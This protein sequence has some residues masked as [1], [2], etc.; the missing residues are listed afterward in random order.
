MAA[1]PAVAAIVRDNESFS[2]EET[3]RKLCKTFGGGNRNSLHSTRPPS[4][5]QV[6]FTSSK[7]IEKRKKFP[8]TSCCDEN[9]VLSLVM[10]LTLRPRPL[11]RHKSCPTMPGELVV[12]ANIHYESVDR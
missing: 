5:L 8:S 11:A 4:H 2:D 10:T 1:S 6:E 3:F 7:L 9:F 12:E